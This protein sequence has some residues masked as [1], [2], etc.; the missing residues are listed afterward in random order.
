MQWVRNNR[1]KAAAMGAAGVLG[2]GT[3]GYYALRNSDSQ[4]TIRNGA[5]VNPKDADDAALASG[6]ALPSNQIPITPPITPSSTG[7][8]LGSVYGG[9]L[10]PTFSSLPAYS[11]SCA[12]ADGAKMEITG[13]TA[14]DSGLRFRYGAKVTPGEVYIC[15][16]TTLGTTI[17]NANLRVPDPNGVPVRYTL[18]IDPSNTGV[19]FSIPSSASSLEVTVSA[20]GKQNL[21]NFDL[22]TKVAEVPVAPPALVAPAVQGV[23]KSYGAFRSTDGLDIYGFGAREKQ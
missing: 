14:E 9:T 5:L 20:A 10:Q 3:A 15:G 4:D 11:V 21:S 1:K 8:Q 13:P 16:I 12:R 17:A 18:V 7:P 23:Q 6:S 19:T 2:L 22:A